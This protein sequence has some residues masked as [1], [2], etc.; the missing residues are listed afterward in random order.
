MENEIACLTEVSAD[1]AHLTKVA[2]YSFIETNPWFD[3][4][5]YLAEDPLSPLK[6]FD[7]TQIKSIYPKIQVVSLKNSPIYQLIEAKNPT[8]VKAR[9]FSTTLLKTLIFNL[10][11]KRVLYFSNTSLFLNSV[12]RLL[13][14]NKLVLSKDSLF[15]LSKDISDITIQKYLDF[16]ET[17]QFFSSAELNEEF[18]RILNE[19]PDL[20]TFDET[21][22]S[23]SYFTN[24]KFNLLSLKLKHAEYL[25]FDTFILKASNYSRINLIWLQK[26]NQLRKELSRPSSQYQIPLKIKQLS[27]NKVKPLS[28]KSNLNK[29]KYVSTI[30]LNPKLI[31]S[32]L[33]I[34]VC[35][36]CNDSF[37]DGAKVMITSFL[38]NNKWYSGDIVIFY[39]STYSNLSID[40]I[41]SLSMIYHRI[42][43]K[44]VKDFEYSEVFKRFTRLYSGTSRERFLPSFFTYDVFEISKKY[45]KTLF[46]DSDMLVLSDISEIFHLSDDII[47]TPDAGIYDPLSKF[48][49]FNGGFIL[50][51]GDMSHHKKNLLNFSLSSNNVDLAEQGIMNEYFNKNVTMISSDFNCL[52][53]CFPDANF[54]NFSN[55]IKIIHYVGSKPWNPNKKGKELNYSKLEKLWT[56]FFSE[57]ILTSNKKLS[58]ITSSYDSVSD[59]H[60]ELNGSQIM[61]TN[62]GIKLSLPKIDYY[63]CSVG[64]TDLI[65]AIKSSTTFPKVYMLTDN[66]KNQLA[67]THSIDPFKY[68]R[69]LGSLGKSHMLDKK[70]R[71]PKDLPTSG[72]QLVYI[73]SFMDISHLNIYGINLYTK[74]D[75]LG[76]YKNI[77]TT[78]KEN[79]YVMKKKPHNLYTDILFLH[80]S[81]RRII[82]NNISV[83]IDN[84]TLQSVY[85]MTLLNLSADEIFQN[86]KN[87][88]IA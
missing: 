14:P 19:E 87:S 6:G 70:N 25:N 36:V 12:N 60:N 30:Q 7:L 75:S 22:Y 57:S 3:G 43:F 55:S 66:V 48:T 52:K 5:I 31:L 15:Y 84:Y 11:T 4:T 53:R 32:N 13:I 21:Y 44:E 46:L 61:T 23:A 26:N 69:K 68:M 29:I 59:I 56:D 82:K 33:N 71:G 20:L 83:N 37:V 88:K 73:A 34:C 39:N 76:N 86:I 77:G 41:N 51:N 64:D 1:S 40:S 2:I 45:N 72:V 9:N 81:F 35:T 80:D 28:N 62:W 85:N 67:V 18:Y 50:C 38:E 78:S 8:W 54:D 10:P 27:L 79:P 63:L 47:V 17:S 49:T 42:I 16:L 74:I 24:S 58:I 65:N